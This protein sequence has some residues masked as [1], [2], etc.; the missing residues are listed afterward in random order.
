MTSPCEEN[1]LEFEE[2]QIIENSNE[3][4]NFSK[5]YEFSKT[6]F[7]G[8]EFSETPILFKKKVNQRYFEKLRAK[9][10]KIELEQYN[11]GLE[12]GTLINVIFK[13][14]NS[15]VIKTI[16]NNNDIEESIDGKVNLYMSG[17]YYIDSMEFEYVTEEHKI[18]Q[19]LYLIKK[20]ADNKPL[21]KL[22]VPISDEES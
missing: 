17:M 22:E 15:A 4:V 20:S 6:E 3:G 16:D 14:Y 11:L 9:R 10:L 7:L 2:L 12:R 1:T 5:E 19:Y 21:N 18:K 13:E 8:I